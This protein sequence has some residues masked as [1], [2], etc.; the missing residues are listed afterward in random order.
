MDS[1]VTVEAANNGDQ[2]KYDRQG[3]RGSPGKIFLPPFLVQLAGHP[4]INEEPGKRGSPCKN[5]PPSLKGKVGVLDDV[6]E[7]ALLSRTPLAGAGRDGLSQN[8]P[9]GDITKNPNDSFSP[10]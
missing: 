1:A 3:K 4:N 7:V 5:F 2:K 6:H 8:I 9:Q 10:P